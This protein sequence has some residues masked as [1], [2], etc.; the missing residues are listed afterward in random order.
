MVRSEAGLGDAGGRCRPTGL[1]DQTL[2]S[3]GEDARAQMELPW[4]AGGGKAGK[5]NFL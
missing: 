5:K 4:S 1:G 3:G 2:G